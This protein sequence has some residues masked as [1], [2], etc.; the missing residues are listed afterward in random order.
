LEALAGCP[1]GLPAKQALKKAKYEALLN[2]QAIAGQILN[3]TCRPNT[4]KKARFVKFGRK[5][6]QMAT[7]SSN[8]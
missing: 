3:K 8:I 5:K 2:K 7:M 4:L 1:E 6:G